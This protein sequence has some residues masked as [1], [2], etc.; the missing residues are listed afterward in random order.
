MPEA[1][2]GNA[3]NRLGA[4]AAACAAGA[5]LLLGA[6]AAPVVVLL[7]SA[8]TVVALIL[9]TRA[10][11]AQQAGLADNRATIIISLVLTAIA[12]VFWLLAIVGM[13]LPHDAIDP[14]GDAAGL[15]PTKTWT[16]AQ[17]WSDA[18]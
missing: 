18:V 8:L 2:S 16:E 13:F 6:P 11:R 3:Q 15:A 14:A 7:A 10:R 12:L 1:T 5:V 4:W 9:V 17:T